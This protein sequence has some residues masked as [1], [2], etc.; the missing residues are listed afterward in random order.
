M[1]ADAKD[2]VRV[3]ARLNGTR[4]LRVAKGLKPVNVTI[5]LCF[6]KPFVADRPWRKPSDIID[7]S[8]VM[9]GWMNE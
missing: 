7:V 3:T 6:S 4:A 5:R 9:D 8:F 1:S 2:R